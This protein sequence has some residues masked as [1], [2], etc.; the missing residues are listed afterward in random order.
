MSGT[1]ETLARALSYN[2]N[3]FRELLKQFS[4]PAPRITEK[5]QD[6]QLKL[7]V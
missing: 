7:F 2:W 6:R 4:I 3:G 5:L 1:W